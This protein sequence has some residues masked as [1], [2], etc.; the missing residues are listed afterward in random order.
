MFDVTNYGFIN[1]GWACEMLYFSF[2]LL[3]G[4]VAST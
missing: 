3:G 2:G 1:V 4:E